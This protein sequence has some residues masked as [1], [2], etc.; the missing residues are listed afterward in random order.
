LF[1]PKSESG[2][3]YDSIVLVGL[4]QPIL[5]SHAQ[6]KSGEVD[7]ETMK[8]VQKLILVHLGLLPLNPKP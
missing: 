5:K 7:A 3:K 6:R 4:L 2:L 8:R 1:L